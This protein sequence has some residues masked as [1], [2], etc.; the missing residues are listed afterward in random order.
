MK[1]FSIISIAILMLA[2][3]LVAQGPGKDYPQIPRQPGAY[4][5]DV[6]AI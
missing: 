4:G 3:M 2:S 5:V 6:P 1:K